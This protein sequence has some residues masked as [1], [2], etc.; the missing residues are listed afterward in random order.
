MGLGV[1]D[2]VSVGHIYAFSIKS[3]NVSVSVSDF[4]MPISASRQVS[5]LPFATPN[6]VCHYFVEFR[7]CR[8]LPFETFLSAVR[9]GD[10]LFQKTNFQ[11]GPPVTCGLTK[12]F[13]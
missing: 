9:A 12:T 4:K 6:N 5:D 10:K 1:S 8:I 13:W 3:L 11:H 7:L 2:F